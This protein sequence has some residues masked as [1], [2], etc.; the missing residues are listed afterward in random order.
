MFKT[1]ILGL[2]PHLLTRQ[3]PKSRHD[4]RQSGSLPHPLLQPHPY[5][6]ADADAD[7]D[8]GADYTTFGPHCT[9]L[10]DSFFS[11]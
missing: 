6:D 11:Q 2:L 8:A 5:A 3:L 9:I 4:G 10:T 1:N 7:A